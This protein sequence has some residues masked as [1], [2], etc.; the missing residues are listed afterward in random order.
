MGKLVVG[1]SQVASQDRVAGEAVG[2]FI[3]L[4][5]ADDDQLFEPGWNGAG[6]E[7]SGKV[8]LHSGEDLRPVRHDAKHIRHISALNKDLVVQRSDLRS[9]I[10]AIKPGNS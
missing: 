7:D 9:D 10:T 8:G 6:I 3:Q 2:S 5:G 1:P 4:A